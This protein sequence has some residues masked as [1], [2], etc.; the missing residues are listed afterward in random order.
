MIVWSRTLP[1]VARRIKRCSS[2]VNVVGDKCD[3]VASW[4]HRFA[5]W[6][7]K[8]RGRCRVTEGVSAVESLHPASGRE[9]R[10]RDEEKLAGRVSRRGVA[11]SPSESFPPRGATTHQAASFAL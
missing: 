11:A 10:R 7:E 2:A 3:T 9:H 6:G 8:S 1:A 4:P 5:R